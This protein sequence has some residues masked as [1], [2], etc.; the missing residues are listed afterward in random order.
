MSYTDFRPSARSEN[1]TPSDCLSSWALLSTE[2][3][4]GRMAV[5]ARQFYRKIDRGRVVTEVTRPTW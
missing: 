4:N 2:Y 1:G 5:F 3:E